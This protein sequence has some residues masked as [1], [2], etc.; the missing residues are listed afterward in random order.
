MRHIFRKNRLFTII[1]LVLFFNTTYAQEQEL[2]DSL[3]IIN[4][5]EKDQK[6][7]VENYNLMAYSFGN[8]DNDSS[9]KYS[10]KARDLAKSI[11][12]TKGLATAYSYIARGSMQY[13]LLLDGIK[14]FKLSLPLYIQEGDSANIL[15]SYRGLS[16][17][18]SYGKNQKQSLIYNLKALD[19]A[20][21]LNDSTSLSIIYNNLGAIY[22]ELNS[23]ESAIS[24]YQKSLDIL[25]KNLT[26]S[27]VI[28]TY[29]NMVVLQVEHQKY[30]QARTNIDMVNILLPQ[31]YS[32]YLKS[33]VFTSLSTFYT[34]TESF[35]TAFMYLD[36]AKIILDTIPIPQ[37]DSRYHRRKAELYLK[38]KKYQLSIES[39]DRSLDVAKSISM[40]EDFSQI[41]RKKSEAYSQLKNYTKAYESLQLSLRSLDSLNHNNIANLLSEYEIEQQIKEELRRK[42]LEQELLEQ[43][44]ENEQIKAKSKFR[45]AMGSIILLIFIFAIGTFYFLRIRKNNSLLKSQHRLIQKQKSQLEENIEKL[46]INE[47]NLKILNA[48]KDRFFS[49]IAHD[50]K[51][52]FTAI[53]GFT[54]ELSENYNGYNDE[55]RLKLLHI[56]G[57]NSHLTF[58]LLENLL[59]WANSQSGHLNLQKEKLDLKSIIKESISPYLGAAELKHLNIELEIEDT[60]I[61][62]DKE[63]VKIIIS[64]L[65]NNATKYSHDKGKIQIQSKTR[66]E[67]VELHIKDSGIGMSQNIIDGLFSIEKNVQRPGTSNEKGTGLGL[68]LC[69]EFI[70]KNNGDIG[71]KS[72]EGEGS[73]FCISL[74]VYKV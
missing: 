4:S 60:S 23:Y 57:K 40:R 7:L 64:N 47:Q 15:D 10:K 59:A 12:Y 62:A 49:I 29:S 3:H 65:F 28:A 27:D 71:V 33:Y 17:V 16:Y 68:I 8:I 21:P 53:I 1:L 50:L 32:N 20:I 34:E 41:H 56:I 26:I 67:L 30:E 70:H 73:E 11:G 63:T 2:I 18:Y 61:W 5:T 44:L 25:P 45:L 66:K 31:L 52:P 72:I 14:N 39:F 74:P 36:S 42:K 35:D 58:N 51:S 69:Q 13:G 37:I 54:D 19:I 55:E 48:T 22:T 24:N 38:Q 9:L 43:R 6:V 46:E